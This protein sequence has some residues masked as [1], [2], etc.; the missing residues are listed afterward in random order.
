LIVDDNPTNLKMLKEVL[1]TWRMR[2]T[3][4]STGRSAVAAME[5]ALACGSPFRLVLLDALMPDLDGFAAAKLIKAKPQLAGASIMMLSSADCNGDATLCR[6]LGVACYVRKPI[7]QSELLD[8]VMTALGT[9]PTEHLEPPRDPMI[10]TARG[11]HS[12]RI[13]VADDNVVNQAVASAM[14]RKRGHNVVVAGDGRQALAMLDTSTVDIVFMDIHMPE[15]DGFAATAAIREREKATGAHTA[16]VA[17]TAHAMQGDRERFLA[18]GM[19]DYLS[20]P[21][22]PKELD[23][24]LS[25]CVARLRGTTECEP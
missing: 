18:A 4:M 7:G 12:L 22:R 15:M 24:I 23:P 19:D 16:I 6:E 25:G 9:A 17:L 14:L 20:K 5:S 1:T 13:L 3:A 2:P 11:P 8:A 10:N 21:L